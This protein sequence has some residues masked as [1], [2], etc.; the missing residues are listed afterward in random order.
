MLWADLDLLQLRP[1]LEN[2]EGD[3]AWSH[4]ACRLRTGRAVA[5]VGAGGHVDT[6]VS[7]PP[8]HSPA[9]RFRPGRTELY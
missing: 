1:E 6:V 3:A 2:E 8:G 9:K 4:A 7:P 5:H